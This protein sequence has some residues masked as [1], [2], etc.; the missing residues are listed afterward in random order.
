M[1]SKLAALRQ[2]LQEPHALTRC[3]ELAATGSVVGHLAGDQRDEL[4]V[5]LEASELLG[6]LLHRLD[7]MHRGQS[8]SQHGDGMQRFWAE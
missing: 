7:W 6:Q 5:G 4:F 8:A 3:D 1:L 2:L